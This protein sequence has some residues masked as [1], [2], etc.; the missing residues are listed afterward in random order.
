MRKLSIILINFLFISGVHAAQIKGVIDNETVTVKISSLDITR[1][2]VQN[3]RIKSLKGIRGAYTR[4]NDE[5]NG[6]VYLQP[7]AAYQNAA[8]TVLIETEKNRHFTLLLTPVSVPGGTLMLV[9]KGV[10]RQEAA[11]FEQA[12]DYQTTLSQL[13]K[14][15]ATD[16]MPEGYSISQVDNKTLYHFGNIATLRL[17][18]IYKGLHFE[19]QIYELTNT[20]SYPIHLNEKQF[21]KQGTSAI[22]L[23][24][25]IVAPHGKVKLIRVVSHA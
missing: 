9:P 5:N 22:S 12:A 25:I 14:A 10:D 21:F 18:T 11:R 1:I 6:E 2:I 15:M 24:S 19:G 23:E 13:V 20:Q 3:D 17:K 4:E 16:A 7:T 8:F